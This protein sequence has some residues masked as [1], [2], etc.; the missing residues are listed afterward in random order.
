MEVLEE[1]GF[2]VIEA[3][4]ADDAVLLLDHRPDI[5]LVFTESICPALSTA[6]NSRSTCR[7][8]IATWP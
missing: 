7:T 5:R 6:S 1:A 4:T 2:E 8:T 3:C